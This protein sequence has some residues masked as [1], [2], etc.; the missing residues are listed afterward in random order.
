METDDK[1]RF[2]HMAEDYDRMAPFL[3]P[4]Y[5]FLQQEI[6]RLAGLTAIS[7]PCVIDLGAGS[8]RLL[9]NALAVCPQARC[10]WIDSSEGFLAVA[11]RRLARYGKQATFILSPMEADWTRQIDRPANCIFSMSAIHHLERHEKKAL[12]ARC[13]DLLA[14]SGWFIN[15]DEM[16]TLDEGAY[17]ASLDFWVRHIEAQAARIPPALADNCRRWCGHFE[18]WK[19]RNI[20]RI[21]QPKTK[22][23]DLHEPFVDQVQWL[24]EIGF[25]GVD[26]FIKYHL[27]CV[28]G[29]KKPGRT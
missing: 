6:I 3:V 23:D 16:K 4:M 20:E 25:E 13:F 19:R 10:Y 7:R 15:A 17:R 21:D 8:G 9:E 5:D 27:W 12:Y 24:R 14:P 18:G 29:G 11:S 26:V 2:A 1:Q 22:G 28:I